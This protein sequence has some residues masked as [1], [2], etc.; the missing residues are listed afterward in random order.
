[1]F[2]KILIFLAVLAL[3]FSLAACGKDSKQSKSSP[4]VS[5]SVNEKQK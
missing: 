2:K 3:V 5:Q 4:T 1:M